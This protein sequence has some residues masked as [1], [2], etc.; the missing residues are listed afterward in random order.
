[1]YDEC[2]CLDVGARDPQVAAMGQRH[3]EHI[4][5]I[6]YHVNPERE[7]DYRTR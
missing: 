1:M 2:F 7:L 6:Q 5:Y 4:L 3:M